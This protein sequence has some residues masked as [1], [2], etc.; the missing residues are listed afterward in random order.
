MFSESVSLSVKQ[1]Y[2]RFSASDASVF[3]MLDRR[4]SQRN[5][6]DFVKQNVSTF[7]LGRVAQ[8]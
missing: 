7:L 4:K 2:I 1:G 6:T 5:K 8:L 3:N